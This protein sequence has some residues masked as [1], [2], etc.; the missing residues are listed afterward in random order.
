MGERPETFPSQ[1]KP[2]FARRRVPR[3]ATP[4]TP[5]GGSGRVDARLIGIDKQQIASAPGAEPLNQDAFGPFLSRARSEDDGRV[6]MLNLLAIKADGGMEKYIEYGEA[7]AS[8]SWPGSGRANHRHGSS[9][10]IGS[11]QEFERAA[12]CSSSIRAGRRSSR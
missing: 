4:T 6:V 8:R 1:P 7:V 9:A 10:L 2:T 3:Q 12:L 5:L 11:D